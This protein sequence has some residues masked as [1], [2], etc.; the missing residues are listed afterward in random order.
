MIIIVIFQ[1]AFNVLIDLLILFNFIISLFLLLTSN[2]LHVYFIICFILI[3]AIFRLCVILFQHL[4]IFDRLHFIRWKFGNRLFVIGETGRV[5][6][7]YLIKRLTQIGIHFNRVSLCLYI[8]EFGEIEII[9]GDTLSIDYTLINNCALLSIINIQSIYLR[10]ACAR[11][12]FGFPKHRLLL[13]RFKTPK[14]L[15]KINIIWLTHLIQKCLFGI[16]ISKFISQAASFYRLIQYFCRFRWIIFWLF[17][18]EF[19]HI[20]QFWIWIKFE[21]WI[22]RLIWVYA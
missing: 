6:L 7:R 19:V 22:N 2:F 9:L 4:F 1:I 13:I 21:I 12:C 14:C 11:R 18:K 17:S 15:F 5:G 16:E 20:F 10:V 3:A 8:W